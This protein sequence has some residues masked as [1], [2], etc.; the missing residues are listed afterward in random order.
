MYVLK[1]EFKQ[2]P[3]W[4][5]DGKDRF[6]GGKEEKVIFLKFHYRSIL[7]EES[8]IDFASGFNH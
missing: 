4:W 2:N 8:E 1:L 5:I 7:H 6:W 3:N